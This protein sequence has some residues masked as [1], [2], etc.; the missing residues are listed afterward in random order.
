[1]P[2]GSGRTHINAPTGSQDEERP[3][4]KNDG[5]EKMNKIKGEKL[6]LVWI[7]EHPIVLTVDEVLDLTSYLEP[8]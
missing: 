3:D 6:V 5:G 1:L 8:L 2:Y 7:K 4:G